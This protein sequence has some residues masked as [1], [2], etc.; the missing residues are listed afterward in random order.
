MPEPRLTFRRADNDTATDVGYVMN[1]GGYAAI[2]VHDD[3]DT[4][5]IAGQLRG[6]SSCHRLTLSHPCSKPPE[7][8]F[9]GRE[10]FAKCAHYV[11][12]SGLT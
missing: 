8:L 1:D 11:G 3:A 7:S 9:Q 4:E 10:L 12:I 5:T 2:R 6:R